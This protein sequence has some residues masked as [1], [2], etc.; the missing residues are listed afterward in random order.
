MSVVSEAEAVTTA[1]LHEPR[2]VLAIHGTSDLES[3]ILCNRAAAR[4]SSGDGPGAGDERTGSASSAAPGLGLS[5][6]GARPPFSGAAG[7]AAAASAVDLVAL[8]VVV[9]GEE[10]EEDE[11]VAATAAGGVLRTGRGGA[12]A[13]PAAALPAPPSFLDDE[14]ARAADALAFAL[15]AAGGAWRARGGLG[16][17]P[18]STPHVSRL[19]VAAGAWLG[20]PALC[21]CAA[22]FLATERGFFAGATPL[23]VLSGAAAGADAAAA[24]WPAAGSAIFGA[25]FAWKTANSESSACEVVI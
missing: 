6:G 10:E 15:A 25:G 11:A 4:A 24:G 1:A 18:P 21:C 22:S 23:G 2:G 7:S 3:A 20:A 19:P 5:F 14:S 8:V 17:P 12:P 16:G 9:V 13:G